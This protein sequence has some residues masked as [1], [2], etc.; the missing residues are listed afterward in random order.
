MLRTPAA[1]RSARL[2]RPSAA[3][4]MAGGGTSW[5]E[6]VQAYEHKRRHEVRP[7]LVQ[8]APL[9]LDPREVKARERA[10][11]PVLCRLRD[12]GAEKRQQ[13][14]EREETNR[15]LNR[16]RDIQIMR[17][18]KHDIINHKSKLPT[19]I[20]ER[21]A[22]SPCGVNMAPVSFPKTCVDYNIISNLPADTH[23]WAHPGDRPLATERSATVRQVAAVN[24]KDFNIISNRYVNDHDAKTARDHHLSSLEATAKHRQRNAFDPVKQRFTCPR[25]EERQRACEDARTSEIMMRGE[26]AQPPSYSGRHTASFNM[27]SHE[28]H[29]SD[30]MR[31]LDSAEL[32]RTARFKTR[33]DVER[34]EQVKAV[35]REDLLGHCKNEN[36]AH[37]RFEE[38]ARRG[39]DILLNQ[40]YGD[41]LKEKR[42]P[43]PFTTKRKTPW[44]KVFENRQESSLSSLSPRVAGMPSEMSGAAAG[45]LRHRSCTPRVARTS[46]AA[47]LRWQAPPPP[48]IPGSPMGSVY[49]Q[50]VRVLQDGLAATQPVCLSAR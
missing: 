11:D 50:H 43:L 26:V 22:P 34:R 44:E 16:S 3:A 45:A 28:V 24:L 39:Y 19:S 37:E 23:H 27:I 25:V 36:V 40:A 17:E 48:A 46:A 4:E 8:G 38:T 33:H 9:R 21:R 18:H 14:F 29:D 47:E 13:A 32:S 35:E 49:S 31:D 10:Y 5:A 6:Q 2:P 20:D 1:P 42:P 12:E 7:E 41:S 30:R 15:Y